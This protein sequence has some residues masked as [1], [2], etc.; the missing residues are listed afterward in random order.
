[1]DAWSAIEEARLTY[2]RMN[3]HSDP[4]EEEF[5]GT[6]DEEPVDDVRLPSTFVHSPAWSAANISDCLAL[7]KALGPVTLFITFTTNPRWPEIK[8]QLLP[9]QS[10]N[11]RPD[12]IVRVF[13]QYLSSFMKDIRTV[14]GPILYHI[15]VTEFQK[16]GL[17]HEHIAVALKN[18]PKSPAEID[19]FLSAELPRESGPLRDAVKRHMTHTHDPSKS[20]HRCGWPKQCQYGYPKPVIPESSFNERGMAKSFSKIFG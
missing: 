10:A 13:Q 3:Q 16:R 19:Q 4:D 7:R 2:I 12:L 5:I 15:R 8:S 6:G 14:L 18:V 1:V 9:N 11:D 17:P 20:Y